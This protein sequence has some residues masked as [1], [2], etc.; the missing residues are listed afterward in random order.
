MPPFARPWVVFLV[1]GGWVDHGQRTL[2]APLVAQPKRC[3]SDASGVSGR[4]ATFRHTQLFEDNG[5]RT[6][7]A[8]AVL[9][10][11]DADKG[12]E[13]QP[14]AADE[15][16]VRGNIHPQ[17]QAEKDEEPA[18]TWIQSVMIM[19]FSLMGMGVSVCGGWCSLAGRA[20]EGLQ[21]VHQFPDARVT[22]AVIEEVGLA[23]GRR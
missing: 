9:Q 4:L 3:K 16:R 13:E 5:Q 1:P 20:I 10:Q 7:F 15:E 18:M 8:E 6:K 23:P 11:V 2:L 12:G 21:V 22:D 14:V 17:S 19:A